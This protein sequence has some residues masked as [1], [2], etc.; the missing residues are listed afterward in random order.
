M[1]YVTFHHKTRRAPL[2]VPLTWET[3]AVVFL[4]TVAR[5]R[6]D[7]AAAYIRAHVPENVAREETI[8]RRLLIH[9][10]KRF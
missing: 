10:F 2:V 6:R 3:A 8:R 9:F 5:L 1:G 7:A 4:T